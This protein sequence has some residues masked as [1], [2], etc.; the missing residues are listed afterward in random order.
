MQR[1]LSTR[2]AAEGV[3]SSTSMLIRTVEGRG[4]GM[5]MRM[6][7]MR[8]ER[9]VIPTRA[10]SV[11][12]SS[13][14]RNSRLSLAEASSPDASGMKPIKPFGSS[15]WWPIV[16]VY[17]YGSLVYMT[18]H[19]AW[20]KLESDELEERLSAKERMLEDELVQILEG[21]KAE[22]LKEQQWKTEKRASSTRSFLRKLW[23]W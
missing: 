10:F 13:L 9:E 2:R 19:W 7:K 3:L 14:F 23:P 11:S 16:K 20:W 4:S 18:L 22:L 5:R 21:R 6:I 17:L 1:T 12:R 8:S 15:P